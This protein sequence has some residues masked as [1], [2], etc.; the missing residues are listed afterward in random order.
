MFIEL[1]FSSF[2]NCFHTHGSLCLL[3]PAHLLR[4]SSA[5][6]SSK[7]PFLTS[8]S[9]FLQARAVISHNH[10]SLWILGRAGLGSPS[11][12]PRVLL[13][14]GTW[15]TVKNMDEKVWLWKCELLMWMVSSPISSLPDPAFK[16]DYLLF[17]RYFMHLCLISFLKV[18]SC[19]HLPRLLKSSSVHEQGEYSLAIA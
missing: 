13:Q 12:A 8:S 15:W 16:N 11:S 10:P 4:L 9:L 6:I 14:P 2:L 7:M 3:H 18:F 1:S 19:L 17:S 5:V